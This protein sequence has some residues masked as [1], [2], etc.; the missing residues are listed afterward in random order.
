MKKER[1]RARRV[2]KEKR[3]NAE[4]V[5][6]TSKRRR[7]KEGR[8]RAHH[9]REEKTRGEEKGLTVCTSRRKR[10]EREKAGACASHQRG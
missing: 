8:R 1:R 3:D 5:R 9:I 4:G 7:E 2:R 10:E 6:I